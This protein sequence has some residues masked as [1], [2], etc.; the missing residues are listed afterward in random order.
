MGKLFDFEISQPYS[1]TVRIHTLDDEI[2][3]T[4]DVN[5]RALVSRTGL[6]DAAFG[7]VNMTVR[8]EQ[9]AHDDDIQFSKHFAVRPTYRR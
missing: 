4:K 9:P 3:W 2:V 7:S 6:A 8:D 1:V 5:H